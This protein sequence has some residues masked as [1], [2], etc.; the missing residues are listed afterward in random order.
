M[1]NP[2][3]A[4]GASLSTAFAGMAIEGASAA[5]AATATA[6]EP[7]PTETGGSDPLRLLF[8]ERV[9]TVP[10]TF[11]FPTTLVLQQARPKFKLPRH[12]EVLDA[13]TLRSR[14]RLLEDLVLPDA[15]APFSRYRF[16]MLC[17]AISLLPSM[18][19]GCAGRP[20]VCDTESAWRGPKAGMAVRIAGLLGNWMSSAGNPLVAAYRE[21]SSR[22]RS[23]V[24]PWITAVGTLP[25]KDAGQWRTMRRLR[26]IDPPSPGDLDLPPALSM[27]DDAESPAPRT[28]PTAWS[29]LA[30]IDD[31]KPRTWSQ[32][33]QEALAALEV[34][35]ADDARRSGSPVPI[36]E[37]G[38]WAQALH[39]A[40]RHASGRL[41]HLLEVD[42]PGFV[43]RCR[44]LGLAELDR[45]LS[46]TARAALGGRA[47]PAMSDAILEVSAV[48]SMRGLPE[49]VTWFRLYRLQRQG[50]AGIAL[51]PGAAFSVDQWVWAKNDMATLLRREPDPA[52]A[53]PAG[54]ED[55]PRIDACR[56]LGALL[57][58]WMES[59]PKNMASACRN[60]E[61]DRLESF[62]VFLML[63]AAADA[64][65]DEG[66][67]VIA[68]A[69]RLIGIA[70][71][72]EVSAPEL[73]RL[74]HR[75]EGREEDGTAR[76][77]RDE[78]LDWDRRFWAKTFAFRR[79]AQG[80]G[81]A[82]FIEGF[83]PEGPAG[84]HV[85]S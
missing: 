6:L 49:W 33:W 26:D 70:Q 75:T 62:L 7:P 67:A 32:A 31:L 66:S 52:F 85:P 59:A 25:V 53:M 72:R 65:A 51:D 84:D 37:G 42:P 57:W 8:A 40:G 64:F 47:T 35:A 18:R 20:C 11:E 45:V 82:R 58:G 19:H 48:A 68:T 74:L 24:W 23:E 56:R 14:E 39:K 54:A 78:T 3:T 27:P 71:A 38:Q 50:L 22:Q 28:T 12:V 9:A 46:A 15:R 55:A 34:I 13:S 4:P 16:G 61:R 69:D 76:F 17:L 2:L 63:G 36:E 10:R 80:L 43:D 29:V 21:L 5:T 83:H 73:A 60:V 77:R 44:A 79:L 1:L 41:W 30:P 81:V